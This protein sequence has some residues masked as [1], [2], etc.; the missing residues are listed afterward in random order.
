MHDIT[1]SAVY[2]MYDITTFCAL[3]PFF[4][5][6]RPSCTERNRSPTINASGAGTI[7]CD[8]RAAGK[9]SFQING[10]TSF[11]GAKMSEAETAS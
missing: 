6:S 9:N 5:V 8:F 2:E 1:R 10:P 4:W 7:V 11:P 3:T